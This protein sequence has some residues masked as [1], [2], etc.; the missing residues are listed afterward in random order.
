MPPCGTT[1]LT[2][3]TGGRAVAER[4]TEVAV[5]E[6]DVVGSCILRTDVQGQRQFVR[7]AMHEADRTL[8]VSVP[9]RCRAMFASTGTAS[10][11]LP[12]R[13]SSR[14][15]AGVTPRRPLRSIGIAAV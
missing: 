10:V 2:P 1:V 6:L 15:F 9:K 7:V 8:H 13:R 5:A 3:L 12:A 4:Q 14:S 11:R